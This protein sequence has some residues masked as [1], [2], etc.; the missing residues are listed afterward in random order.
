MGVVVVSEQSMSDEWAD[1]FWPKC[2]P[3]RLVV[4]AF[5][6]GETLDYLSVSE[7]HPTANLC[8]VKPVCRTVEVENGTRV[9]LD[10]GRRFQR[11]S[12]AIRAV[13]VV[14]VCRFTV[15]KRALL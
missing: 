5:V 8:I 7:R 1:A 3:E 10:Q 11:S 6:A 2:V 13:Y 15:E 14:A 9:C 12:V 4:I